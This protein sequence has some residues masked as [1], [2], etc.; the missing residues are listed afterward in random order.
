MIQNTK[1]NVGGYSTPKNLAIKSIEYGKIDK[2]NIKKAA[3]IQKKL[4]LTENLRF[5]TTLPI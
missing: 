3:T 1:N 5:L 2:S 4:S